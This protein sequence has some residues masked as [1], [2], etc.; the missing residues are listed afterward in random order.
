[1]KKLLLC[2]AVLATAA[3]SAQDLKGIAEYKM[4]FTF[5]NMSFTVTSSG[6]NSPADEAKLKEIFEKP[7]EDQYR[8]YFTKTESVYEELPKLNDPHGG[9]FSASGSF[10]M[11]KKYRNIKEDL[12]ISEN[13]MYGKEFLV[14]DTLTKYDWKLENETK[15]IGNYTCYKATHTIK[16]VPLTEEEKK[17]REE[18]KVNILGDAE[19]KDLVITAWYAPEIPVSHGPGNYWGLP[20][21]IL[22]VSDNNRQ[23]LCTKVIL[24]PKEK[25]EV[26]APKKGQKVTQK[27]FTEIMNKKGEEMRDMHSPA[28]GSKTTTIT[29]GN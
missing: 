29:F 4:L 17:R 16:A 25:F 7:I 24:N 15:K 20:G 26:K 11:G 3:L 9:D 19:P 13:D 27:E 21:L 14:T 10:A 6:G 1:M 8:L 23:I 28:P 12:S 2:C 5:K 18:K 22:E